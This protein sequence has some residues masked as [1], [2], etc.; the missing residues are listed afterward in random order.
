MASTKLL[1]LQLAEN[2]NGDELLHELLLVMQDGKSRKTTISDIPSSNVADNIDALRLS[3][4]ASGSLNV[5]GYHSEG[6]GGGGQ[7]Y[8]DSESIEADNGG[9]I[10]QATGVA[11]G[12]WK[13][14][15]SGAL[16]LKWFG[17]IGD[18]VTDDAT[19]FGNAV[20]AS[21]NNKLIAPAGT[22]ALGSRV[23][24]TIDKIEIIGQG[25]PKF[26]A[27][28]I[29]ANEY[30]FFLISCDDFKMS[31]TIWDGGSG[32]VERG[33]CVFN[34][35]PLN[36]QRMLTENN[37]FQNFSTT[38]G[39][40]TPIGLLLY[41]S[42]EEVRSVGDQF[43]NIEN[44]A[45]SGRRAAKG[46]RTLSIS[47]YRTKRFYVD[48]PYCKN[49]APNNDADGVH[50][51]NLVDTD[52]VFQVTNGTFID[53][54]KRGVKSQVVGSTLV[55]D[56]YFEMQN[57]SGINGIDFQ[58]GGGLIDNCHMHV[59]DATNRY[60][61]FIKIDRFGSSEDSVSITN[62]R[63]TGSQAANNLVAIRPENGEGTISRVTIDRFN[64][65]VEAPR[66]ISCRFNGKDAGEKQVG[67][68]E[69][70]NSRYTNLTSGVINMDRGGTTGSG[71]ETGD[72]Q[73]TFP[74]IVDNVRNLSGT[75][76]PLFTKSTTRLNSEIVSLRST[77]GITTAGIEN[78]QGVTAEPS[79]SNVLNHVHG[80]CGS[81][82]FTKVSEITTTY[83][84]SFDASADVST[85]TNE[86]N[87]VGH[88]FSDDD[89]IVAD[90]N[91]NTLPTGIGNKDTR[92]YVV[93]VDVDTIQLSTTAGGGNI[94]DITATGTGTCRLRQLHDIFELGWQNGSSSGESRGMTSS[95]LLTWQ[96]GDNTYDQGTWTEQRIF[97][98]NR[99]SESFRNSS[100]VF[101]FKNATAG[102]FTPAA[103][104]LDNKITTSNVDDAMT[105]SI[106]FSSGAPADFSNQVYH[107]LYLGNYN[108]S[109]ASSHTSSVFNWLI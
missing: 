75:D 16:N 13:R 102:S 84:I 106:Y 62:C 14:V 61:I 68:I 9:T 32:E 34:N 85:V 108:K 51:E 101:G 58:Y 92:Y 21:N 76:V 3:N 66:A 42:F 43:I 2:L 96:Y 19:A 31:G 104:F 30:M 4:G 71:A 47:T 15:Y 90:T 83:D 86:I 78:L 36:G 88:P 37:I 41:G 45:V 77:Y 69:L 70:L 103:W 46:L 33:V 72:T 65:E 60:G 49:I 63:V 40:K 1:N 6:D 82:Q 54:A 100:Q 94:V 67:L 64:C 107:A 22:Y 28:G 50:G 44:L 89:N 53:C 10:I 97:V 73:A 55:R 80:P 81:G 25:N 74:V 87:V 98:F 20:S 35:E 48:S 8:W 52:S 109:S 38:D 95:V 24:K 7:F 79:L 26:I 17:A 29:G 12:R 59:D 93:V 27:D 39:E 91:G 105:A 18:G 56:C 99:D 5:L 11:T 57:Y 23:S